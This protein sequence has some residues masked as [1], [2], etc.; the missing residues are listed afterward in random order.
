MTGLQSSFSK[1]DAEKLIFDLAPFPMWIYELETL[2]FLAVNREAISSYGY[3][4]AE[5]LNMTLMDIRPEEDIPLLEQAISETRDRTN[6]VN[7]D[8]LFRHQKK[9]GSIL[10][11]QINSNLINYQGKEA[12]IVTAIDLTDRYEKQQEIEGQKK[13]LALV[14][15]INQIFL[16]SDDWTKA[17]EDS[18]QLL[19]DYLRVHKLCFYLDSPGKPSSPPKVIWCNG[20]ELGNNFPDFNVLEMLFEE[21]P[22]YRE[23]LESGRSLDFNAADLQASQTKSNFT[24][25]KVKSF[26]AIPHGINSDMVGILTLEDVCLERAW[27][28]SEIQ[29]LKT[30]LSNL[31]YKINQDQAQQKLK[32]SEAR[33]RSLVQNGSDLTAIIDG[34]GNYSYVAPTSLN[35]LGIPAE[36]FIGKNAFSFIHEDDVPRL[37]KDL[38]NLVSTTRISIEPYRFLDAQKNWR[39][40]QTELTNHLDD[41]IISGIIANTREVTLEVE[42]RLSVN[43]LAALTRTI[44]Q[45]ASLA[46]CLTEAMKEVTE[47]CHI[48][49]AEMWLV[50]ED[51][52]RLDLIAKSGKSDVFKLFYPGQNIHTLKKG[53][54]FPGKVWE[55]AIPLTLENI[56]Q[57]EEFFRIDHA[58]EAG[59]ATAVGIPVLYNK[60]FLGCILCISGLSKNELTTQVKILSELGLQ[61][62]AVLKQK[63]TEEQYRNFFTIS[64]DPHGILGFDGYLKKVNNA[65]AKILG[66]D[67]GELLN[68][69]IF[70]FLLGEDIPG[71]RKRFDEFTKGTD[72]GSLEIRFVTKGGDIKWLVW[73]GTVVMESQIIFA[74]AKDITD[75][76]QA[77]IKLSNANAR[78]RRAQKIAKLGYWFRDLSSEITEWSEETYKIHGYTPDNFTPTMENVKNT[79]HPEDRYL[80][81]ADPT[82]HIEP[83]VVQSF[84]HRIIT[85]SDEV[86]W[87]HQEIRILLDKKQVPYRIEGTLQDITERKENELQLALSN[88][89][90]QLAIKASNEMIWEVDHQKQTIYRGAG[91]S[92]LVNYKENEPFS[93]DN[94]WCRKLPSDE[95]DRVWTSLEKALE[96]KNSTFW[97]AEYKINAENGAIAYFVDRCYILRDHQGKPLRSIGSVLDI[98]KSRQQL[99]RIKNQNNKLREI[100]WLQSHVIRAPLTRI[101]SLIYLMK[102]YQG[103]GKSSE[104]IFDLISVAAEELDRV[105]LDIINKTE[106]VKENDS[107]NPT[108]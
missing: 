52:S 104:E 47:L 73:K 56:H 35:V 95:M 42:K 25:R 107:T 32:D 19:G 88:E 26:M 62:A 40:I 41:P 6:A 9:D 13:S 64:P 66:Y 67:K 11:V 2:T 4:E 33:F 91:Y 105:I 31:S 38:E 49:V 30:I 100:A 23:S 108:N 84:E 79:F 7:K 27:K 60:E 101:M 78:L 58:K 51:K 80:L 45:P 8:R 77:E 44:S 48:S 103:G 70:S 43:M 86:K 15:G 53:Q 21:F 20:E 98:T 24:S 71:A 5:F 76:K 50:A 72:T 17:L 57:N 75:Q 102:E 97:S 1:N 65:F 89:R 22:H 16:K 94:S 46:S 55:K 90:F 106:A 96:D 10:Y 29:I 12:Q 83:G 37:L 99:E 74:V 69:S 39:W 93:M 54:G 36:E 59:L 92:E 14:G 34:Q 81:E 85:A 61:L 28:A 3:S 82:E 18:F 87:V 68:K 63:M